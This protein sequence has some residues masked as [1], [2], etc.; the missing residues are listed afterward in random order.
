MLGRD[1]PGFY[2]VHDAR[3]LARLLARSAH[4]SAFYKRLQT[5]IQQRRRLFTP[6]AERAALISAI[7]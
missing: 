4:D 1:Y 5:S 3:A 6:S 7:R 2:P